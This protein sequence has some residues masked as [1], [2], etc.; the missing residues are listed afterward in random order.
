MII[1]SQTKNTQPS[2]NGCGSRVRSRLDAA[3]QEILIDASQIE[4]EV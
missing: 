1:V 4:I 3:Q 2:L